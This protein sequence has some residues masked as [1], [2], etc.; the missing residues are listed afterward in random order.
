VREEVISWIP[1][2]RPAE[3]EDVAGAILY[4]ESWASD[5]VTGHTLIVDGGWTAV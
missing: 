1:L 3:P 4:L 2:G 5:T